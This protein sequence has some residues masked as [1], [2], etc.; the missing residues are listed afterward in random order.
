MCPYNVYFGRCAV[1]DV[2]FALLSP[3]LVFFMLKSKGVVLGSAFGRRDADV[4]AVAVG[5]ADG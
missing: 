1:D 2:A 4:A 5:D 3:M